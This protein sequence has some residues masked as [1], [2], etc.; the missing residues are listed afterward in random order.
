MGAGCHPKSWDSYSLLFEHCLQLFKYP[1]NFCAELVLPLK[2][3]QGRPRRFRAVPRLRLSAVAGEAREDEAV[4]DCHGWRQPSGLRTASVRAL[5]MQTAS[6][7]LPPL[8]QPGWLAGSLLEGKPHPRE[9]PQD[10]GAVASPSLTF[11]WS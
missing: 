2:R 8:A 9:Q 1:G 11:N 7:R 10:P 6:A 4:H 5:E 3:S